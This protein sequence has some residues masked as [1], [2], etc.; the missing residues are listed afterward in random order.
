MCLLCQSA[1][2]G[3]GVSLFTAKR[4]GEAGRNGNTVGPYV[5]AA[6]ACS[7]R[8]R[9]DIPPWL[10][11]RDP[12]EVIAER[13]SELLERCSR[14]PMRSAA[15][16]VLVQR[17]ESPA[18]VLTRVPS[19][20]NHAA[21]LRA[22]DQFHLR[23]SAETRRFCTGA[24]CPAGPPRAR[25]A[26]SRRVALPSLLLSVPMPVPAVGDPVGSR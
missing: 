16:V 5:C 21:S 1:L 9:T 10:R 17:E 19:H 2:A 7:H 15:D 18:R 24:A 12:A 20:R 13:A 25:W 4:A 3:D 14:S 8:V 6:L 11:E 26:H 22:F 23:P